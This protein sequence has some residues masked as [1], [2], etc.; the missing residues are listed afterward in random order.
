MIAK[1]IISSILTVC[2]LLSV[3]SLTGCEDDTLKD[4][5][6]KID[7]TQLLYEDNIAS[8]SYYFAKNSDISYADNNI[9]FLPQKIEKAYSY[10]YDIQFEGKKYALIDENSKWVEWKFSTKNDGKYIIWVDYRTVS[11]DNSNMILS[12]QL[13]GKYPYDE[14]K[15]LTLPRLWQDTCGNKFNTDTQGN[16]IKPSKAEVITDLSSGFFDE[17]GYHADC[18]ELCVPAGEHT[19]RL[20]SVKGAVLI[21]KLSLKTTEE[22]PEYK[23]YIAANSKKTSAPKAIVLEAEHPEY[24]N[25]SSIYAISDWQDVATTPNDS[26]YVK[27]NAIGDTNWSKIGQKIIWKF[28]VENEGLYYIN[29]RARQDYS[30]GMN[31]YRALYI[32]GK[33]PFSEVSSVAFKYDF[34]WQTTTVGGKNPYYLYLSKGE[35][36]LELAVAPGETAQILQ[37][38]DALVSNLNAIYRKIIIVTGTTVDIY[39]DYDLEN[40]IPELINSFKDTRNR[41]FDISSKIKKVNGSNGS[42]ASILDATAELLDT[43]IAHP[44]KISGGLSTYK[45]KIEDIA[46]L[47]TNM[48]EQALLLDKITFTPKDG[49]VPDNSAPFFKRVKFSIGKFINSYNSDKTVADTGKHIN[50]WVS[51]GR[52]QAQIIKQLIN[53]DF[54]EK[55]SIDVELNIVDTGSTLIQAALAGKGPDLAIN[56]AHDTPVNLAMRGG[57]IDLKK[58][59]TDD[60]YKS[61]YES[62]WTPFYYKDGIYGVP[63]TQIF[64]MLFV[65]NDIM[66]DLGIKK[67]P[68][69]WEDFYDCMEVIQNNNLMIGLP[70]TTGGSVAVSG[71]IGTFQKLYFQRGNTYY[72]N[73]YSETTFDT[74]EAVECMSQ[75]CKLYTKYGL[76]REYNFLNRFRSGELVMGISGYS[77]YNLIIASAPEIDGLW[78]MYPIPGTRREDGT[79][80]RAQASTGTASVILKAAEEHGVLDESWEFVKWWTSE[81]T[82]SEY[83]ERLEGIMGVAARYTPANVK[84]FKS[85]RWSSG[86][87]EAL[88]KQWD[89]VYNIREIPGNYYI[90]RSLTSAIRNTISKGTSIR[91]NLAKYNNDINSEIARKR[92]E[93]NV[94]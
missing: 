42:R 1:R 36:T 14:L 4:M 10:E 33:I 35:H 87:S 84:A 65:R 13:D 67:A 94:K 56:I 47:L 76:D 69:T 31:A 59:I 30:E 70:E 12:L 50:V 41:L 88:L 20:S 79:V 6:Y 48:S 55:K 66:K 18:Y 82:Q 80:N 17:K 23:E 29:I 25:D 57:L 77:T 46:S 75:V 2:L 63:E 11:G 60:I 37:D 15:N 49:D 43:F 39:Q 22:I 28:D 7:N 83:A 40:K 32:D 51:T 90:A 16:D 61:F 52:D 78:S 85:I 19:I 54:I 45:T 27:L 91:F 71:A 72:R 5:K 92:E 44:Y 64:D 89:E 62:S 68:D 9:E 58:Y 26:K 24:T 34:D 81:E 53:N 74:E 3:I 38:L 21:G 73:D 8:Y 93:F 86:E